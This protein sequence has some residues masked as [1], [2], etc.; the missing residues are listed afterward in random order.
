VAVTVED[1]RVTAL[2]RRV[3]ACAFGQAATALMVAGAVGCDAAEA[4]A[5]LAGVEHWLKG[6]DAAVSAWPG[7]GVLEPARSRVGRH[8]AILL[9][10]QALLGALEAVG[11]AAQ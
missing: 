2:L 3:E 5:A 6:D 10:F 4:R 1:G 9:P 11:E 7:L 8:G